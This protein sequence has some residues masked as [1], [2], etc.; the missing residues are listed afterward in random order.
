MKF[1]DLSYDI[2]KS[3]QCHYL[4]TEDLNITKN[5]CRRNKKTFNEAVEDGLIPIA[6][7]FEDFTED[8][9]KIS[10][11][12]WFALELNDKKIKSDK[13]KTLFVNL[14]L[15][16]LQNNWNDEIPNDFLNK[17]KFKKI[18]LRGNTIKTIGYGFLYNCS[19]LTSLDLSGLNNVKTIGFSFLLKCS[20]LKSLD[21]SGFNNITIIRFGFLY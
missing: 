10:D 9:N 21:L 20:S 8:F 17:C 7:T 2:I 13:I 16:N 12:D 19:S 6:G 4:Q 3:I 5:L 11:V 18:I 14:D 15:L 1:N